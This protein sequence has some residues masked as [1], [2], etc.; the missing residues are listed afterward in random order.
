M[1]YIKFST[2]FEVKYLIFVKYLIYIETVQTSVVSTAFTKPYHRTGKF[3][4]RKK[5]PK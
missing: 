5:L 2:H 4:E 3:P 1:K